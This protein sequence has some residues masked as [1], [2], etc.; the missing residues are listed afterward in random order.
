M[1]TGVENVAE[2]CV[3]GEQVARVVSGD[4]VHSKPAV[5]GVAVWRR[6]AGVFVEEARHLRRSGGRVRDGMEGEVDIR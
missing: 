2:V 4:Q 1:L 5:S 3:C 6:R